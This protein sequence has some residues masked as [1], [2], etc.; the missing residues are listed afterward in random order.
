MSNCR[1]DIPCVWKKFRQSNLSGKVALSLSTW[2]GTGLL[3]VMPGTFGTLAAV[4]LIL[5]LDNLGAIYKLLT[6]MT[7]IAI[8]IWA[9]GMHQKLLD[10]SD[11]REIVIDEVAGFLLTMLFLPCSWLTI[12]LGFIFFRFFDILKPYPIKQL[13]K[14]RGGFGVVIDDLA[15][16]LY[17]N[18]I[19][20]II[21]LIY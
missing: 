6:L 11:P 3:P 1:S 14:L 7:A 21:L 20:R 13:E 18:I 9:S 4:P 8:A 17:A 2:I 12:S 16:G 19:V 15:A 10:Q 5:L